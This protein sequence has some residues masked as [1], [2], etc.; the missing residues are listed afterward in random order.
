MQHASTYLNIHYEFKIK[1]TSQIFTFD[2]VSLSLSL[3]NSTLNLPL[4]ICQSKPFF[5]R[6][7]PNA[8]HDEYVQ[9]R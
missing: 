3:S 4:H 6:S 7:K 2:I 5:R 1:G 9:K 8:Q